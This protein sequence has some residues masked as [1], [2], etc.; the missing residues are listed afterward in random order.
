MNTRLAEE[1]DKQRWQQFIEGRTS[2]HHAFCWEWRYIFEETFGHKP[3]Y[4]LAEEN[5]LIKGI[6]PIVHVKSALFG[7]AFISMPY[8]N[9]GGC[10]AEDPE[11]QYLLTH[12]ASEFAKT[13]GNCDYLEL[14]YQ[15]PLPV[16]YN[17]KMI[18][19]SHKV[20]MVM[21]LA[22][23]AEAL[24][25]SFKP[26]LRSQIRRPSKSGIFAEVCSLGNNSAQALKGFYAVFSEHMRDL[27][28][29][30]F[31][32]SLFS[33]TVKHFGEQCKIITVWKDK[34]AIAAGITVRNGTRV[35]IPWASSLRKYNKL[36]PNML[37]YWEA[38]KTACDDGATEFDFGRSSPDSG[39]Y[40]FKR[41][42]GSSPIPLYWYYTLI[43]GEIPN[44]SP[45]N[46]KY[47]TLVS[48]WKR[49]PLPVSNLLGPWITRSLP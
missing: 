10:I 20:S 28:T 24:F 14:R 8:L 17:E 32:K 5:G 36:S 47:S 37:L 22:E 25:S 4:F 6:L 1:T 2:V 13:L 40:K 33:N 41:Q 46:P 15:Q 39:P 23:N 42:W 26:K 48:C 49:L 29:P 16:P 18:E 12:H 38:I 44:I 27:G 35:E 31:P 11:T 3:Y 45:Q 19:R 21:P 30:V 9:A 43:Q 7:S 34:V